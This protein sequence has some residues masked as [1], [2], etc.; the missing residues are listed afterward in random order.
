[1]TQAIVTETCDCDWAKRHRH[2]R[3]ADA[4]AFL[5]DLADRVDRGEI[6]HVS[7]SAHPV[8]GASNEA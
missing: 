2:Y 4:A 6:R 8:K 5:R 7:I 3:S 1:M